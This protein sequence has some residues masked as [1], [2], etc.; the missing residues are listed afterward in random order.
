VV[1]CVCCIVVCGCQW[2]RQRPEYVDMQNL[3]FFFDAGFCV[4]LLTEAAG[5]TRA[6]CRAQY[7]LWRPDWGRV[8]DVGLLVRLLWHQRSSAHIRAHTHTHTNPHA[9]T[10]HTA[11]T[12]V[13]TRTHARTRHARTHTALRGQLGTN[14]S[15]EQF[16]H[17]CVHPRTPTPSHVNR[18]TSAHET[19]A[20]SS[21]PA[22]TVSECV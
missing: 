6:D 18:H 22:S 1:C 12:H 19:L 8:L 16:S 5:H 21:C 10:T 2:S 13:R 20:L 7:F 11:R 17:A 4:L 15:E 9:H 14:H 3:S